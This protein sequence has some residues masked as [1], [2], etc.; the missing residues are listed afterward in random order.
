[1]KAPAFRAEPRPDPLLATLLDV[2]TAIA[3][4]KRRGRTERRAR[5]AVVSKQGEE[6]KR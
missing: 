5:L 6:G 3:E 1:V 2:A 4:R